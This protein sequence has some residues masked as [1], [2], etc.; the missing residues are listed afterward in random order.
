M[1]ENNL[2]NRPQY[3]TGFIDAEGHFGISITKHPEMRTGYNVQLKIHITQNTQ[4]VKVL[5]GIKRI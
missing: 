5:E 4:S 1:T 2:S 3:I